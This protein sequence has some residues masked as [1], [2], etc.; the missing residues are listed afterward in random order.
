[1][2][3]MKKISIL[4]TLLIMAVGA[5]GQKSKIQKADRLFCQ[6]AFDEAKELYQEVISDNKDISEDVFFKLAECYRLLD[7][8]QDAATWYARS[9]N[10]SQNSPTDYLYYAQSLQQL[11]QCTEAKTW[12][13]KYYKAVPSDSRGWRGMLACDNLESLNANPYDYA[14]RNE[15]TVNSEQS[16]IS[17][18][19]FEEGIIFS[20]DR[21]SEKYSKKTFEWTG[22]SFYNLMYAKKGDKGSLASPEL[23]EGDANSQYHEG[24]PTFSKDNMQMIYSK[25]HNEKEKVSD[26]CPSKLVYNLKLVTSWYDKSSNSW[27]EA[28]EKEF[29]KINNKDYIVANPSLSAD[30][31]LLF[32]TSNN[33][34]FPG[35]KGGTDIYMSRFAGGKWSYPEN[36]GPEINSEG[37]E[38]FPYIADD[39]T[40][41]FS[42]NSNLGN[43][44]L[45]GLD[46]YKATF[47]KNTKKYES[48]E[49]LGAPINSS[50][51]DFGLVFTMKDKRIDKG[52]FTSSRT[53][54]Q[55]ANAKGSD[56]IY[57]FYPQKPV[58][59]KVLALEDCNNNPL[60]NAMV[61]ILQDKDT[62]LTGM[63]DSNGVLLNDSI[64]QKDTKYHLIGRFDD[65]ELTG[66]LLTYGKEDGDTLAYDFNF[67]G[68]LRVFGNINNDHTNLP[69][70]GAI[71]TVKDKKSGQKVT[72]E[73]DANGNYSINLKPGR[74]YDV[75]ISKFGYAVKSQTISTVGRKCDP[76][77]ISIPIRPGSDFLVNVYYYF[78]K[79]YIF[80]YAEALKDLDDLVEYL[81]ENPNY[82]IE[83]RSHTDARASFKYNEALGQRRAQSVKDYLIDHGIADNRLTPVSY[84]E[85]CTLNGCDDGVKCNEVQHQRN[86]RTEIKVLNYDGELVLKTREKEKWTTD[87]DR[88][89]EGGKYFEKGK[90]S[91][92]QQEED[93]VG[94]YGI[95]K[96]IEVRKNCDDVK[97]GQDETVVTSEFDNQDNY[98]A[99]NT[100]QEEEIPVLDDKG[101][102]YKIQFAASKSPDASFESA[103][104][105]GNVNVEPNGN[106]YR[107]ML[108]NYPDKKQANQ[109]LDL[110][111]QE[112]FESAYVVIYEDG[113]RK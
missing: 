79:A 93:F 45:G 77:E 95:W 108:G 34:N 67:K 33:K 85:Y 18:A 24:P 87:E 29:E 50:R 10:Y 112:G 26:N 20:T 65:Q 69:L 57:Y 56:D 84:G 52:Y 22:N 8:P 68:V 37:D 49:N 89:V 42:S 11:E 113:T 106:Y 64:L 88:Y 28:S 70:E 104:I 3:K 16:D 66:D 83:V 19:F 82:N 71:V 75:E 40:L 39:S 63:T 90:G 98:Y 21:H 43:G 111:K 96:D 97:A 36:L 9:V 55:D 62:I 81:Q 32:F 105:I 41:Y 109:K 72:T 44:G 58:V 92:W 27:S 17:P 31:T 91:N 61:T 2:K 38:G 86:R 99:D 46:I 100:N 30:G 47:N 7:M 53:K 48:V 107:Y 103:E 74:E 94:K 78:D 14:V 25:T 51:D 110:L 54:A 60:A 4:F 6:M 73:T 35:H 102:V 80:R 15:V 1:M 12:F 23:L 101:I 76:I 13:D 5:F 59:L